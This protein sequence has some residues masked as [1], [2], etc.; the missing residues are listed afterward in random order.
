[1]LAATT[2]L[3]ALT[4]LSGCGK[5]EVITPGDKTTQPGGSTVVTTNTSK[6]SLDT[7]RGAITQMIGGE[8]DFKD[9]TAFSQARWSRPASATVG[10]TYYDLPEEDL[11]FI[12]NSIAKEP[13]TII[14]VLHD[15]PNKVQIWYVPKAYKGFWIVTTTSPKRSW[16]S[17]SP[18]G[19]TSFKYANG[20]TYDRPV[21]GA[22]ALVAIAVQN[23]TDTGIVKIETP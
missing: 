10:S 4:L 6:V 2:M 21:D 23:P 13:R 19:S 22:G 12:Y 15:V 17:L 8:V 3:T 5:N 14:N 16:T 9:R 20:Q 7:L 18:I 1:M 11:L